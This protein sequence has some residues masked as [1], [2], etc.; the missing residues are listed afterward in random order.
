[1]LIGYQ[2]LTLQLKVESL[3]LLDSKFTYWEMWAVGSDECNGSN[4]WRMLIVINDSFQFMCQ[5]R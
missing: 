5:L 4:A 2:T 3:E 1:M